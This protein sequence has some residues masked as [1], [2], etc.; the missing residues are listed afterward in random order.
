MGD[1]AT[2]FQGTF[3]SRKVL[4]GVR[5][6]VIK[7][8]MCDIY[9]HPL[10]DLRRCVNFSVLI[11]FPECKCLPELSLCF[12][13][14]LSSKSSILR[15]LGVWLGLDGKIFKYFFNN[16]AASSTLSCPSRKQ[17]SGKYGQKTFSWHEL[18]STGGRIEIRR[19]DLYSTFPSV[20][21]VQ[22]KSGEND[23]YPAW[24]PGVGMCP[25]FQHY[26]KIYIDF[27]P[28]FNTNMSVIPHLFG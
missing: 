14:A 27:V 13:G 4:I 3:F 8:R 18:S 9:F 19:R 22:T 16:E 11:F 26:I 5:A 1:E 10:A 2:S 21:L 23:R 6:S 17:D 12:Q 7:I 24:T 25:I 28:N 20:Y 15:E